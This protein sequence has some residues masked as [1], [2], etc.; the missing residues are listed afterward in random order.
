MYFRCD[1]NQ[2]TISYLE[3]MGD[4]MIVK[5][6]PEDKINSDDDDLTMGMDIEELPIS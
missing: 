2:Y 6:D 4:T 5:S 1:F 3:K